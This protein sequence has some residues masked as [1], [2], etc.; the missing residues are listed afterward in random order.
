MKKIFLLAFL[1]AGIIFGLEAQNRSIDFQH[2]E[3]KKALKLAKKEKKLIFV[4]CYTSWCGP[5]KMLAKDVFTQDAVGDFFNQH[6]VN[7][8]LDMEKDADG[9]ALKVPFGIK[10]F[11]T[12]VFVDPTTQQVVHR[13]VGAGSAEWLL[14][15]AKAAND[16]QNNL[17]GLT[18]RY[19]AGERGV[20][21]LGNYLNALASAYMAKEQSIV[22]SE[23]LNSLT[24]EQ[25]A[26]KENWDLIVKNVNDP[27][28]KPLKQVMANR[29]KFYEIAG[30]EVVEHKLARSMYMAVMELSS[31]RPGMSEAFNE[32]RNTE[33]VNYLLSVDYDQAPAALANLYTAA[34]VRKGDFRGIFDK[35]QEVFSYNLF[36]EGA[37]KAY[38]Q[39][40]IETLTSCDD[41]ALVEEGI[42]WI[43]KM[44][45]ATDDYFTKADLMNSKARLQKKNG[46]TLGMDKSKMEEEKYA[47]EAER[48]SGGRMM[49]AARMN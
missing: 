40:Y 6:F 33:L 22:A 32:N 26:T 34:L 28:S 11:P 45:Q 1:I 42:R 31:W 35:M 10:A 24:D 37:E 47:K 13:M 14:A 39:N 38:F 23:Y 20:A 46:D 2:I 4:D 43:D 7:L 5:C 15:G 19:E 29:E 49:R 27:L 16:P 12:L 30:K 3:W 21:F 18:K 8:K 25:I 48:R 17:S 36:R 41:K 44:C 9:V